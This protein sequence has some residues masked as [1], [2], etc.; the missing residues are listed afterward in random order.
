[1]TQFDSTIAAVVV[2]T[3]GRDW[4]PELLSSLGAQTRPLDALVAVDNHSR[5]GTRDLLVRTL[6]PDRVLPSSRDMGFPAAAN[7]GAAAVPDADYLLILHDDVVLEPDTVERLAEALD[8]DPRLG[9]T[10]P[11]VVDYD[12]PRIIQSMG[13]SLDRFGQVHDDVRD[14]ELD[15]GQGLH[16][17]RHLAVTSAAMMVR[18][19]VFQALGGFDPR[20]EMYRDDLDLCWRVWLGGWDV[21]VVPDTRVR[22]RRAGSSDRRDDRS[23]FTGPHYFRER[24]TLAAIIKNV[25]GPRIMAAVVGFVVAAF[26]RSV[27][28]AATRRFQEAWQTIQAWGWNVTHLPGTLRRRAQ[29]RRHQRRTT[30]QIEHLFAKVGPQVRHMFSILGDWVVGTD[31][32][33]VAPVP[34][35]A[36]LPPLQRAGSLIRRRPMRITGIALVVVGLFLAIPLMFP[37]VFRLG[38]FAP[39]P[40]SG[41]TAIRDFLS[42]WH[43]VDATGT[44]GAPSPAQPM[45][46]GIQVLLLNS[47]WLVGRVL[48][49]G[50]PLLAWVLAQAALVP[51]IP[52]RG[53]RVAGA[54]VY[55]LSPAAIAA[56]RT[57]RIGVLVTLAMLPLVGMGLMA[58]TSRTRPLDAAWRGTAL[59]VLAGATMVAFDSVM[60]APLATAVVVLAIVAGVRR[61]TAAGRT[62]ALTRLATIAL[63]VPALLYPWIGTLVSA[64]PVP[65]PTSLMPVDEA[66][67]P[68]W[69]WLLFAPDQV[70]F[71]GLVAGVGV[72]VAGL[73]GLALASRRQPRTALV[74]SVGFIVVSVGAALLDWMG[75]SAP[76]W[77]GTASLGAAALLA[78]LM[79]TG[80]RWVTAVMHGHSFGWRQSAAVLALGAVVAGMAATAIDIGRDGWAFGR[81]DPPLPLFLVSE[82]DDDVAD[83]GSLILT[84]AASDDVVD[85][86]LTSTTGDTMASYGV[87]ESPGTTVTVDTIVAQVVGQADPA[88]SGRLGLLNVQYVW[89]PEAGLTED[90]RAGLDRQFDLRS[91]PVNSGLVYRLVNHAPVVSMVPADRISEIAATASLPP[92]LEV[93]PLQSDGASS[94]TAAPADTD[95]VALVGAAENGPWSAEVDGVDVAATAD[96]GLVWFDVPAG[97]EVVV[98][99]GNQ[100]A[101]TTQLIVELVALAFIVS[102]LL[103]PPGSSSATSLRRVGTER[104]T[105]PEGSR[106]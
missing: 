82:D 47:E 19:D 74:L 55:I 1:M 77:A 39:F 61:D 16:G 2:A 41:T 53:P 79:A 97:S 26:V 98:Q 48:L 40:A 15:Q 37:G 10:G 5:D 75:D 54:T 20:F 101:R 72:V 27:W 105:Q 51:V 76:M 60:I 81:G 23:A 22:H 96:N 59:A 63:G 104:P 67:S 35:G 11:K 45:L 29:V 44:A 94:W 78:I 80:L 68:M 6:G 49:F 90:L 13:I 71:P 17:S 85:W 9:V 36:S 4:V 50:L 14:A 106:A 86:E 33:P 58:A 31:D 3:D 30:A 69:Q 12:N 70:G 100:S 28:Y 32:S 18:N 34:D 46:G 43:D 21:A 93:T 83:T 24:N 73:L 52:T 92:T 62:R 103:R 25:T 57:G 99:A 64:P 56:M 89:V 7:M 91:E 102:I 42:S 87:P 66:S 84:L 95:R 8:A 88:A 65:D 38:Q